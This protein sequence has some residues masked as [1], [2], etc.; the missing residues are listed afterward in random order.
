VNRELIRSTAFIRAARRHL[1]K[2]PQ[3]ADDLE[4]T[5]LLL[6]SNLRS[7]GQTTCL[8]HTAT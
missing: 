3:A 8:G 2:H 4:A 7:V 1:K 5:L 6:F